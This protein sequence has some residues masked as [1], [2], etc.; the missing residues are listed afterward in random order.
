MDRLPHD[1][2][3]GAEENDKLEEEGAGDLPLLLVILTPAAPPVFVSEREN[4]GNGDQ[5]DEEG[6][7]PVLLLPIGGFAGVPLEDVRNKSTSD[8]EFGVFDIIFGEFLTLTAWVMFMLLNVGAVDDS[9]DAF[10]AAEEFNEDNG[11]D[12]FGTFFPFFFSSSNI[13]STRLDGPLG[14]H[15]LLALVLPAVGILVGTAAETAIVAVTLDV[16]G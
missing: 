3:E 14:L 7:D 1:D 8:T 2:G 15:P 13:M 11:G 10:I 5:A 6:C 12:K 9:N 4:S 16:I